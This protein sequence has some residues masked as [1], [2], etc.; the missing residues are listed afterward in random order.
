MKK[1][2]GI[3]ITFLIG[4]SAYYD[5]SVGTLPEANMTKAAVAA[6][7]TQTGTVKTN[8]SIPYFEAVVQ[9]G[10][11]LISVVE[12]QMKKPL[13]VS[14]TKLLHDFQTLNHGQSP[15]KI[16]IGQIYRFPIYSQ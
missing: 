8:T 2:L 14:M 3:L 9:P 10:D 16:Q 7:T 5:L 11:T 4:Y 15:E 6:P 13:P 1:W 12:Q